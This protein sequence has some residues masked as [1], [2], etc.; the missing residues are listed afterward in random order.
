M[1]VFVCVCVCVCIGWGEIVGEMKQWE[2]EEG[3]RER[4]DEKGRECGS[5][6]NF[7][8][9]IMYQTVYQMLPLTESCFL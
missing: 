9:C 6:N 3:R 5:N 2:E 1:C 8:S 7:G 4:K